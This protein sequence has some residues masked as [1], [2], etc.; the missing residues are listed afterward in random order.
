MSPD[1]IIRRG[2]V[3]D[4]SGRPPVRADVVV[5]GGQI[6]S[7]GSAPT[8]GDAQELDATGLMVAPGFIDIHSHS[9]YTLLIDPRAQSAIYQGVTL[10]VIG[11]CGHGCF[12]VRD[13]RAAVSAIYG[14]DEAIPMSWSTAGGYFELLESVRPAVNV[15]SLVP[16]GQL[17]LTAVGLHDR[18]A[19][20][21][22]LVTMERELDQALDEGAWGYS[23]GLEYAAE[24]AAP[25]AEV[26]HLCR[27]VARHDALYATHTRHRDACAVEAVD[28]ALRAAERSE[29]RLQISHLIPRSGETEGRRCQETVALARG[30]GLD[31]A[32]DMHTR[33]FGFT[34]LATVLPGWALGGTSEELAATL[35][36]PTARTRL[37]LHPSIL[38]AGDDWDRIVLLPNAVWPEYDGLSLAT[39]AARRGVSPLDA[40]YDLLLRSVDDP[41]RLMVMIRCHTERQQREVFADPL[42]MPGSD[43]TTLAPDGPLADSVFHGAYG[44]AAWFYRFM[45]RQERLLSPAEAVR[46]LTALPAERLGIHDRGV[47]RTGARADIAVFDPERFGEQA[48]TAEPNRLA[49]GMVHVV[50]NGTVTLRSS[51]ATGKRG[52]VVLRRGAA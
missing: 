36:D 44:W 52:G 19:T 23:T 4:G 17:R 45:V 28:E 29:A 33:R 6:A 13:A 1:L 31:V 34:F 39:I 21:D 22:E 38:R 26:E 2:T 18:P 32:F 14:F 11:N 27:V 40:T 51:E 46:R 50:V 43:A 35:R 8:D 15:A 7:I 24:A 25:A 20:P 9:D 48:T 47:L 10:E 3:I 16:N 42:C 37:R 5:E 41:H 30:R 49:T 12:P